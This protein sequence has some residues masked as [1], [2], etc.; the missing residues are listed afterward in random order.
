LRHASA[1]TTL[2]TPTSTRGQGLLLLLV[3]LVE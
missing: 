1:C 3:L 2:H